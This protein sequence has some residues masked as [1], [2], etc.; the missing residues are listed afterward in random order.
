MTVCPAYI[1]VKSSR[2]IPLQH[3]ST[4]L[5]DP[6]SAS[7]EI[8]LLPFIRHFIKF[9]EIFLY[10]VKLVPQCSHSEVLLLGK[11]CFKKTD[12]K[13]G[14]KRGIS[15]DADYGPPMYSA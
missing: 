2:Q 8:P 12:S 11:V 15:I 6:E 13:F 3:Q 4:S 10:E 1:K 14:S 7:I 9:L 5:G